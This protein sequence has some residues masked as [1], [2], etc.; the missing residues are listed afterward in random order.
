MSY[1]IFQFNFFC[2]SA[3]IGHEDFSVLWVVDFRPLYQFPNYL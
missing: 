2:S 1:F 3:E